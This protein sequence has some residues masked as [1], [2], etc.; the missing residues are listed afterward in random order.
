MAS[1]IPMRSDVNPWEQQSPDETQLMFSRFLVFRDLGPETDRLRQTLEVLNSTGDSLTWPQ[2]QG[3]CS[4]YRWNARATAWDR[5]QLQADRAR[6]ARRRRKAIDDQHKA[7]DALRSKAAQA[8]EMLN[9]ADMSTTDIVRF[10]ELSWKIQSS[11]FAEIS[12]AETAKPDAVTAEIHD[13]QNWSPEQ[14]RKRM[15]QIRAE[16]SERVAR[17]ANDDEVVA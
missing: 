6:M 9:V 12:R 2:L 3:Y 4:R 16:L 17:A 8:L 13:I 5:Y 10:M 1:P 14:R 7:A 15:D 11:I